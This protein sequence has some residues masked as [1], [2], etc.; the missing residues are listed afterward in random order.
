MQKRYDG[1]VSAEFNSSDVSYFE[2]LRDAGIEDAEEVIAAIE[3]HGTII[4]KEV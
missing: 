4:I 1:Y 2:G 3:K